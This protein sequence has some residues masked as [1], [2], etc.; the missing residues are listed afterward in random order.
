ML[1]CG[2]VK[3]RRILSDLDVKQHTASPVGMERRAASTGEAL[4]IGGGEGGDRRGRG[5]LHS[6]R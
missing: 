4:C 2:G 6:G 5:G 1:R 3:N